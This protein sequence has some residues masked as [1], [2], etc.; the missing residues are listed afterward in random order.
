MFILY[1]SLIFSFYKKIWQYHNIFFKKWQNLRFFILDDVNT[2]GN[3]L[4]GYS[5]IITEAID[6]PKAKVNEFLSRYKKASTPIV[7]KY[8][9][10]NAK[11]EGIDLS[12]HIGKSKNLEIEKI[13]IYSLVLASTQQSFD[14]QL[15]EGTYITIDD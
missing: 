7:E 3:T 14:V 13:M 2:R 10:R 8:V 12:E 4:N 5:E 6:N 15:E 1:V 9:I 11:K